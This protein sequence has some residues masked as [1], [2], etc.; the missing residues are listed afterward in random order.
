MDIITDLINGFRQ[1]NK[2]ADGFGVT[3]TSLQSFQ[4]PFRFRAFAL[5]ILQGDNVFTFRYRQYVEF[6]VQD[7]AVIARAER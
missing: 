4:L 6:I 2:I 7:Q 3:E 1:L 5:V